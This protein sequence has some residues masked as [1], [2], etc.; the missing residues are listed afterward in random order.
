[1]NLSSKSKMYFDQVFVPTSSALL[2]QV[3][4]GNLVSALLSSSGHG[5]EAPV[6]EPQYSD[7][8]ISYFHRHTWA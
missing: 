4:A 7:I 1:M 6:K 8:V 5:A 2:S 3:T